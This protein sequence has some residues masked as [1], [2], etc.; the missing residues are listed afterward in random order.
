[1]NATAVV[2]AN[3]HSVNPPSMANFSCL[4]HVPEHRLEKRCS[5]SALEPVSAVPATTS[6]GHLSC[7]SW[8]LNPSDERIGTSVEAELRLLLPTLGTACASHFYL[9]STSF[10]GEISPSPAYFMPHLTQSEGFLS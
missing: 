9:I 6:G 1:M 4:H 3:F 8:D 5:Q 7:P 10:P 2:F